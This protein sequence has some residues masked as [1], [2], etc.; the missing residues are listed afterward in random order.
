MTTTAAAERKSS[1]AV[2]SSAHVHIVP[3][4]GARTISTRTHTETHTGSSVIIRSDTMCHMTQL[5]EL[6][7]IWKIYEIL[8]E[9]VDLEIKTKIVLLSKK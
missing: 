4:P 5:S 1:S 3:G 9:M 8:T 7:W 2:P 6:S